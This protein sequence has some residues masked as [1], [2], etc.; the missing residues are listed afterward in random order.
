M[1]TTGPIFFN[2]GVECTGTLTAANGTTIAGL[3]TFTGAVTVSA[4][5][6]VTLP[7]G[8][9]IRLTNAATLSS[10]GAGVDKV[11]SVVHPSGAGSTALSIPKPVH[12]I[13]NLIVDGPSSSDNS[14]IPF[15]PYTI[16]ALGTQSIVPAPNQGF[17]LVMA[18]V[19]SGG[20]S[21][22]YVWSAKKLHSETATGIVVD[23]LARSIP[24]GGTLASLSWPSAMLPTPSPP[25]I[26]NPTAS[27]ITVTGSCV[28]VNYVP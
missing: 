10:S 6:S 3:S 22:S 13:G 12:I 2:G 25:L 20:S 19:V 11:V 23:T 14:V 7:A 28:F 21:A 9:K 24:A 16:A 18:Q 17:L 8:G 5:K 26:T 15:G 1:A 27:E 4:D